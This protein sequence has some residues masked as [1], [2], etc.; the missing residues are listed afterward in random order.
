MVEARGRIPPDGA[1]QVARR[2]AAARLD[3]PHGDRSPR[4]MRGTS[5]SRGG[6]SRARDWILCLACDRAA[7]PRRRRGL[8]GRGGLSLLRARAVTVRAITGLVVLNAS[9]AAL[10]LSLLY[11]LRGFSRWQDVPGSP[12]S[13]TCSASPRSGSSGRSCSSSASRSTGW[14]IVAT[15][16]LAVAGACVAGRAA[17]TARAAVARRTRR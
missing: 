1:F 3:R 8:G 11:A 5:S 17:R 6:P 7:F 10:G 2:R 15:L 16:I 14:G 4:R 12:A 9:F 13:G